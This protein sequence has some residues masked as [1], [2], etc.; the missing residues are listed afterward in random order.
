[1]LRGPYLALMHTTLEEVLA[2]TVRGKVKLRHRQSIVKVQQ[3]DGG[4]EVTFADGT[5]EGFDAL[6]GANGVH[7]R[8]RE[9]V[10]GSELW[11][12]RHLGSPGSCV[13]HHAAHRFLSCPV[14]PLRDPT[15]HTKGR[16]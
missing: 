10:F 12:A 1:V 6:V 13:N 3:S 16:G 2:N 9:L 15:S 14:R 5:Q 7:S 4:V 11:W 8:T